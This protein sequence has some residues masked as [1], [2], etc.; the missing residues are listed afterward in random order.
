MFEKI[1]YKYYQNWFCKQFVKKSVQSNE[2]KYFLKHCSKN[3]DLP[4]STCNVA[5]YD[6]L[7]NDGINKLIKSIYKL[8]KYKKRYSVDTPYLYPKFKKKNYINSNLTGTSSGIIA[9]IKFKN[10]N[11]IDNISIN[12]TYLNSSQCLIEYVFRFKKILNTYLQIHNFV[13][14]EILKIRKEWYFH[15]YA[16]KNIIKKASYKVLW[17]LDDIF[18][19]DILQGYIC[20]I[21]YT[22]YGKKYKLPIEYCKKLHKYNFKK[23]KKL[24]RSLFCESYQKGKKHIIISILPYNRFE[25]YS[26]ETGKYFHNPILLN[27]FSYF[28]TELYYK[29]FSNIEINELEKKM[30]KYLNSRKS[31]VSSKDIK[32]FINKIRYIKEQQTKLEYL[33]SEDG[34]EGV[35]HL[36]GWQQYWDGKSSGKDFINYPEYTNHFLK[37]YEQNLDYLNSLASVQN[38]L[39]VIVVAVATLIATLAGIFVTL[40]K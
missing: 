12:F 38:N 23:R 25:L 30:R 3:H 1:R 24:Q 9:N 10:H 17:E 6:V 19:A 18:F 16:D 8:K 2:Y 33:F 37:L 39:I 36:R 35:S 21:F 5:L 7:N 13:I 32:W 29:A 22:D 34:V 31:F 4:A 27:F 14:D 20:K 40:Q 28:T 26:Y 15:T 11:W